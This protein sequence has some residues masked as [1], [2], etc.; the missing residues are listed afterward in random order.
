MNAQPIPPWN[1]SSS[2]ADIPLSSVERAFLVQHPDCQGLRHP[3]FDVSSAR[4]ATADVQDPDASTGAELRLARHYA[5]A[6]AA[7]FSLML[8]VLVVVGALLW[9]T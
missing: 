9:A 6:Y 8:T 1:L 2:G 3:A 4:D 7:V 5:Y